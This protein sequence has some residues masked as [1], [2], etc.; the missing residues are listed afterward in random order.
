VSARTRGGLRKVRAAGPGSRVR[1]VAPASPFDRDD[2][3]AGLRELGRLGF[4][5]VHD[6]RVFEKS[7]YVAGTA[8]S[9][10]AQLR[11][12]WADP[13]VDL[14][15]AVRGGYGSVQLLPLLSPGDVA[16][17][18]PA[19]FAGYS[20]LT[21][22]HSWLGCQVGVTSIH[23]PMIERRLSAGPEAYDTRSFLGSL[24]PTP[25]GELAPEGVETLRAGEAAGPLFGGTLSQLLGSLGTPWAFAPPAGYV[26]FLDEVGERPY[27]LDRMLTQA[28]QAG[29]L[30]RAS[31]I[32][33]GQ[34]P[35]CD[36]PAATV[37]G[38]AVVADALAGFAGPVL[39]GF[40]SG[41]VVTPLVTLPFGVQVRVVAGPVPRV[42]VEESAVAE[43]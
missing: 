37:T 18:R 11:D 41:H 10:A 33:V 39:F 12:A 27:R 15:L 16:G 21:T 9:R 23:G 42:V 22:V 25:L 43:S 7:G 1:L 26:L 4:V 24:T 13:A 32:I 5:P 19:A 20:D 30:A 29:L 3:D 36:E 38:R 28:V 6:E 14:V 31:A 34:M 17:D 35:R 2:F 40:P 8:Q